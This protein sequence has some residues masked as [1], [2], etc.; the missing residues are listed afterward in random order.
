MIFRRL[1]QFQLRNSRTNDRN[2]LLTKNRIR[3]DDENAHCHY[4]EVCRSMRE[5]TREQ[6]NNVSLVPLF[7]VMFSFCQSNDLRDTT[8]DETVSK[9]RRRHVKLPDKFVNCPQI[10][11]D[12]GKSWVI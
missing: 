5:Q 6:L 12:I 4:R 1:H 11:I 3:K 9:K 7:S 8:R 2:F 10:V